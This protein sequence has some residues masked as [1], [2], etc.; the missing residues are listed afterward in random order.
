MFLHPSLLELY[1]NIMYLH[2]YTVY[3]GI[4]N[5]SKL[6]AFFIFLFINTCYNHFHTYTSLGLKMFEFKCLRHLYLK[7]ILYVKFQKKMLQKKK[8][9]KVY[10][11]YILLLLLTYFARKYILKSCTNWMT[12]CFR[13]FCFLL[14]FQRLWM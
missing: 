12:T 7:C 3:V 2:K 4:C 9:I 1:I 14:F 8:K 11:N 5:N 10:L 6:F 13:C